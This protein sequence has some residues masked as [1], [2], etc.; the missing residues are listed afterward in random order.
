VR[1]VRGEQER[2][3]GPQVKETDPIAIFPFFF[4][5]L[6][7]FIFLSLFFSLLNLHLNSNLFVNF[8]PRLNAYIQIS[9]RT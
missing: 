8:I 3:D 4:P 2:G 7:I 1:A 6:F 5:F 9:V